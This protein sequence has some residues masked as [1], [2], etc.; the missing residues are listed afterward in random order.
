VSTGT[1]PG[2]TSSTL[3]TRQSSGLVRTAGAL[4]VLIFNLGLIS[5]GAA[6]ATDHFFGPAF[7]P[8]SDL[9][10]ATILSTVG[11]ALFVY[12]F[13]FWSVTFPR[14]G[15]NYVFLTRAINP[16]VG[17]SLSFLECCVTL[18]F[19]GLTALFFVTTALAPFFGTMALV[20]GS[21]W[22]SDAGAWMA[23]KNGLFITG[24]VSLVVATLLP[25]AGLRRYFTFQKLLFVVAMTGILLGL[26]A[27]LLTSRSEFLASFQTRTGLTEA[28]VLS[29]AE[30]S[31]WVATTAT[32]LGATLKVMVWPLAWILAGLYSVGFGSE[33]RRINRSQFVGMVG[34]VV[35]AGIVISAYVPAV[36]HTMGNNFVGALAWNSTSAPEASTTV[37]PYV[38][39]LVALGIGSKVIGVIVG[40][41]FVAWYLFLIPAQLVYGQRIMVAWSFDRLM[42]DALGRVSTRYATPLVAT[43]VSFV[44]A[45]GFFAWLV[46]GNLGKLVFVEGIVLVW[47]VVLAVGIVFPWVRP[48]FFNQSPASAYRVGKV[49]LMTIVCA[50]GFAFGLFVEY[51][52]LT[53]S[54]AAGHKAT[55]I[56]P[57]LALLAAGALVY[58]VARAARRAQGIDVGLAFKQLPIE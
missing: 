57:N 15:G 3:F 21:T 9:L 7:Y 30:G 32:D 52:Y 27:L 48:A 39:L 25:A 44:A 34:A 56:L 22:W 5:I 58:L 6:I 40:L 38:P 2:S 35:L 19:G 13:W 51:L 33:I 20:T 29:A 50:I 49:P 37:S 14:A 10:W 43:A 28:Q 24:V 26:V 11:A 18:I 36:N 47:C 23:T 1:T 41:G 12:G 54:L 17:F 55:A 42:P 16:G 46:Y 53:D 4:D 8:G 45:L 31:G